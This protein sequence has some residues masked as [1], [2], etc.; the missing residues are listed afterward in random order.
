M[1]H[2]YKDPKGENVFAPVAGESHLSTAKEEDLEDM[3]LK[4]RE[5][6]AALTVSQVES[7][8]AEIS[9]ITLSFKYCPNIFVTLHS[10]GRR[11]L[12]VMMSEVIRKC[13]RAPLKSSS[14]TLSEPALGPLT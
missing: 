13:P 7:I 14:V 5:L 1:V 4:I 6:E 11:D 10:G 2:L 3:R 12:H 8:R 9:I